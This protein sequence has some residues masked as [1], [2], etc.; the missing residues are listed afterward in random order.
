MG[1]LTKLAKTAVHS[2]LFPRKDRHVHRELF[3][4]KAGVR[5]VTGLSA[6]SRTL[7]TLGVL[8]G[9]ALDVNGSGAQREIDGLAGGDFDTPLSGADGVETDDGSLPEEEGPEEGASPPDDDGAFD[10][11]R[12][13]ATST[14]AGM[15]EDAQV[16][17]KGTHVVDGISSPGEWNNATWSYQGTISNWGP[18]RN[19]LRAL[20]AELDQE[21]L[22][23]RVEGAIEVANAIVV[24]VDSIPD[25]GLSPSALTD[26]LGT[27]DDAISCGVSTPLGHAPDFAWGTRVM[28]GD[29]AFV[30][31]PSWRALTT[32]G[33]LSWV[34]DKRALSACKNGLCETRIPRSVL[35]SQ[36]AVFVFARL[37]NGTGDLLSN[38][39]LP[40]QSGGPVDQAVELMYVPT[41]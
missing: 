37:V 41:P 7:L 2:P 27:V 40:S 30:G 20:S 38:Q 26:R 29:G 11:G 25:V 33:D 1:S 23:L 8:E 31:A 16:V 6:L 13:A 18:D 10:E 34:D 21:F 12:D 4:A 28:D 19:A 36:D 35:G 3:D 22:W 5:M 9:C 15:T 32:P 14:D 17:P 24:F 39:A